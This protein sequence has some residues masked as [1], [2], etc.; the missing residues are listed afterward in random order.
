M[1][2]TIACL[3][4]SLSLDLIYR[5]LPSARYKKRTILEREYINVHFMSGKEP[6][7]HEQT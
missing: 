5:A 3:E 1:E 4:K 6:V 7:W 2:A